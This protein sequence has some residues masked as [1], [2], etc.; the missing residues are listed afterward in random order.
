MVRVL[1]QLVLGHIREGVQVKGV[2]DDVVFFLQMLSVV[3]GVFVNDIV[4]AKVH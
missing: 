4:C 3:Y 1:V 2:R